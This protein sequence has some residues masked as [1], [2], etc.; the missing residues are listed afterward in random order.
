VKLH[1]ATSD[2]VRK[3]HFAS[4]IPDAVRATC[5]VA[6]V[7]WSTNATRDPAGKEDAARWIAAARKADELN[8]PFVADLELG[9]FRTGLD[10][11]TTSTE[12][13]AKNL[14]E[15]VWALTVVKT[16]CP[17]L[18]VGAYPAL[19]AVN[20]LPKWDPEDR[21]AQLAEERRVLRP[22]LDF[23]VF[24]A[25]PADTGKPL[26]SLAAW[27]RALDVLVSEAPDP[28]TDRYVLVY[29]VWTSGPKAGQYVGDHL[30]AAM[31]HEA[32]KRGKVM[33]W[34]AGPHGWG[35]VR[36]IAGKN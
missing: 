15:C 35:V 4:L 19:P 7:L 20:G 5:D 30:Y 11:Y 32:A 16:H 10:V 2:G 26:A 17:D 13:F 1:F 27:E 18:R 3:P 29:D 22:L 23:L 31:I 33:V 36:R 21:F 34:D 25:A 12:Q 24:E 14:A 8:L 28:H 9:H 6:D